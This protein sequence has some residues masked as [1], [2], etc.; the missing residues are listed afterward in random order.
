[1]ITIDYN[2]LAAVNY[3][4]RWALSRNPRFY[5][6]SDIGGDC[7][8]FVSQCVYAGTGVMN[9][10]PEFGWYYI[11]ANDK[12]PSWTGVRYFYDFMIN[13]TGI[14]PFAEER[15]LRYLE[16]GDIIQFG[17]AGSNFYHSVIITGIAGIGG[18]RRYYVSAHSGD[19]Y[20][21]NLFSYSFEKY[22]GI[23]IIGA[24]IDED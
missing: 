22:R 15:D 16:L 7:T 18:R 3:A 24:R 2:R 14:G 20:M 5:D 10:T 4:K 6:Y 13:N 1:M 9:Y 11:N 12:S 17:D 19:V 23:H 8:N 21:K